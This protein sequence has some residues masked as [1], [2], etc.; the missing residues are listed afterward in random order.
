MNEMEGKDEDRRRAQSM[1][2]MRRRRIHVSYEEE[3]DT[4][5]AHREG[6]GQKKGR[7]VAGLMCVTARFRLVYPLRCRGY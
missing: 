1:C 6:R 3:K 2:H 7:G 5:S 4:E